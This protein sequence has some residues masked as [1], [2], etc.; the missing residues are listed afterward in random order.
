[1]SGFGL[2]LTER[3]RTVLSALY[4]VLLLLILN[5]LL[6]VVVNA[7]PLNFDDTRWRVG[8]LGAGLGAMLPVLTGLAL[9]ALIATLLGHGAALRVV[10]V[11]GFLAAAALI[12][13]GMLFGL[14]ALQVRRMV[15]VDAKSGFDAAAF[16]T[17]FVTGLMTIVSAWLA[18]RAWSGSRGAM[19]RRGEG[20]AGL[21]VGQ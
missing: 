19:T 8:F 15:R 21:V 10:S 12:G 14:D 11:A 1:M 17:L 6:E 20:K 2:E 9:I 16:K 5:P 13:G 18:I 7:W 3:Q 4:P